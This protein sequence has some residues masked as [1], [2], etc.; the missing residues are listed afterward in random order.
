[1][2]RRGRRLIAHVSGF[3]ARRVSQSC[4]AS[5]ALLLAWMM[6]AWPAA[7][8][9]ST[10]RR[11]TRL[12]PPVTRMRFR[13]EVMRGSWRLGGAAVKPGRGAGSFRAEIQLSG[14]GGWG[15]AL[16]S[17]RCGRSGNLLGRHSH[18]RP[19]GREAPHPCALPMGT[20]ERNQKLERRLPASLSAAGAA[21]AARASA[22]AVLPVGERLVRRRVPS[23]A[24]ARPSAFQ[25]A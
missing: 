18:H 22:S 11:P 19:R 9:R 4:S 24:G 8:S 10:S 23:R 16:C 25:H 12:A 7:E 17:G 13:A 14:K 1:M 15:A 20:G 5:A 6:T 21:S 3:V 2:H